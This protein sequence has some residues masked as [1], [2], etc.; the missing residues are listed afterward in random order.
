MG[1]RVPWRRMATAPK[2]REIILKIPGPCGAA[3]Y[4][5]Q[6]CWMAPAGDAGREGWHAAAAFKGTLSFFGLPLDYRPVRV[7]PTGWMD[8]PIPQVAY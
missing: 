5:C 6:G 1:V 4:A 8:L 3:A 2:D 7:R